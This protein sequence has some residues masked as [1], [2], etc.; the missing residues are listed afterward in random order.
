VACLPGD[1][2]RYLRPGKARRSADFQLPG[3]LCRR[4]TRVLGDLR[5]ADVPDKQTG[6]Q[7]EKRVCIKNTIL[8]LSQTLRHLYCW[9][10]FLCLEYSS[11]LRSE[12]HASELQSRID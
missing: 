3:S 1:R 4:G 2:G 7:N 9:S 10:S 5:T 8:E 6:K 12:E 11:Y